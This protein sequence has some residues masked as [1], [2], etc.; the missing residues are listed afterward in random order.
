MI[1]EEVEL[2]KTFLIKNTANQLDMRLMFGLP[3]MN[4]LWKLI[5]QDSFEYDDPN[6]YKYIELLKSSIKRISQPVNALKI[7]FPCLTAMFS[8]V[9]DMSTKIDTDED[10]M[11]ILVSMINNHKET[12][13]INKPR[14]IT[15]HLL[16]ERLQWSNDKM[17]SWEEDIGSERIANTLL[18]LLLAGVGSESVSA[19]LTWAVLYM[20]KYQ[21]IQDKVYQ[22]IDQVVGK[23]QMPSLTDRLHLPYTEVT[24]QPLNHNYI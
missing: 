18:D 6:L 9:T 24:Y 11:A 4:V 15:D 14:D 20:V 5:C 13:D 8:N 2:F 7:G 21:E 3:V 12:L 22:E 19:T 16:I 17:E 1:Q 23:E 10:I